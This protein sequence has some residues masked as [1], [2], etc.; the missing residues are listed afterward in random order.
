MTIEISNTTQ[1][2]C[3]MMTNIEDVQPAVLSDL[4]RSIV[5]SNEIH[6]LHIIKKNLHRI[7]SDFAW[8][9]RDTD[10]NGVVCVDFVRN[11][12]VSALGK[13]TNVWNYYS[14]PFGLINKKWEIIT[15]KNI[16]QVEHLTVINP[17]TAIYYMQKLLETLQT[18]NLKNLNIQ[19]EIPELLVS[20][21]EDSGTGSAKIDNHCFMS[22]FRLFPTAR[23]AHSEGVFEEC[24][25]LNL[26]K[27]QAAPVPNLEKELNAIVKPKSFF[28]RFL[29]S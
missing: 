28:S 3:I 9:I 24:S 21:V 29:R 17:D 5:F 22:E 26:E 6:P 16:S 7:K 15:V 20:V 23:Q 14:I 13:T 19:P 2:V 25:A 27:K 11:N 12:K 1:G 10:K 18:I 4:S 8:Y